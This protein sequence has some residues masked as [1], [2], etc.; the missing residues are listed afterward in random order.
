MGV[1]PLE[2]GYTSATTWRGDHE[3]RK[4]HVVA[5]E[6]KLQLLYHHSTKVLLESYGDHVALYVINILWRNSNSV[7]ITAISH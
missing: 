6:K 5:L 7:C 1:I 4:G 2:V 3:V